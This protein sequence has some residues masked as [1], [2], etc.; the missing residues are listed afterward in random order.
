MVKPKLPDS[1]RARIMELFGK[2]YT[3]I[4]IFEEV[5]DEAKDYVDPHEELARTI[6]GIKGKY[7]LKMREEDKRQ[8]GR[9]KLSY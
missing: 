1:L 2:G 3:S 4:E 5:A 8:Y 6:A 9:A 7:T